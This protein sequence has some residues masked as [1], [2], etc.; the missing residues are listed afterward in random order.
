MGD[1]LKTVIEGSLLPGV[2][3]AALNGQPF[4]VAHL[5]AARATSP[6][7]SMRV[8]AH[9]MGKTVEVER[10]SVSF[11]IY[12]TLGASRVAPG[13]SALTKRDLTKATSCWL[14]VKLAAGPGP[15]RRCEPLVGGPGFAKR[16]GFELRLET[17]QLRR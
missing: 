15:W 8:R 10:V 2:L 3:G 4:P 9:H 16:L 11:P 5:S 1:L 17:Q 7:L 13:F 14:I 12:L 6:S